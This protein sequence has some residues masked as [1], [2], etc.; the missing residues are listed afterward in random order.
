MFIKSFFSSHEDYFGR[1]MRGN[2]GSEVRYGAEAN[3][4][5]PRSKL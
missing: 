4:E 3:F 1:G 5:V 2:V